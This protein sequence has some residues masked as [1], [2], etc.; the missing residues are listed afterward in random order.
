[1][2]YNFSPPCLR[3][4][5]REEEQARIVKQTILADVE[6]GKADASALDRVIGE[7]FPVL[8]FFQSVEGFYTG[9]LD[10][11]GRHLSRFDSLSTRWNAYLTEFVAVCVGVKA[12]TS[13]VKD[14]RGLPYVRHDLW[15]SFQKK[16]KVPPTFPFGSLLDHT[17]IVLQT[18]SQNPL[19]KIQKLCLTDLPPELLDE[20]FRHASLDKARLLS[21]TCRQLREIAHPYI[22]ITRSLSF[23]LSLDF[24]K[25]LRLVE[26]PAQY[27]AQLAR[28]SRESVLSASEFL[29]GR[30]ELINRMRRL[31][32]HDGWSLSLFEGTSI[33][34]FDLSDVE[35]DFYPPITRSFV[36]VLSAGHNL[37]SVTLHHI[38]LGL[39]IVRSISF[40]RNLHT[41]DL[42][43]CSLQEDVIDILL[44]DSSDELS[45]GVYNLR[46]FMDNDQAWYTLLLCP[47]LHTLSARSTHTLEMSAP[48]PDIWP[49]CKFYPTLERLWLE[50]V[51][52]LD[53]SFYAAWLCTGSASHLRL[54][55]FKL[56]TLP[57]VAEVDLDNVLTSL[58]RMPL[59]VL[60]LDGIHEG[61]FF[62]FIGIAALFPSLIA[63]TLIR[64]ASNR[65]LRTSLATWPH[66][67]WEYA[68]LLAPL[69]NLKHFGWNMDYIYSPP[70]PYGLL[71][72]EEGFPAEETDYL[73]WAEEIN[74]DSFGI[75][76]WTA[77]SF[78]AY[79]PSLQTYTITERPNVMTCRISRAP[80]GSIISEVPERL[81]N[82]R[83]SWNINH[84]NPTGFD[85]HW[86]DILPESAERNVDEDGGYY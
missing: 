72:F 47:N 3:L 77:L 7:I 74:A 36:D 11:T 17:I 54:T 85:G 70:T 55:H 29:L 68:R 21:S 61:G 46:L 65:Q 23:R 44:S 1:M 66:A 79:C 14:C 73:E 57:G 39:D 67:S 82:D 13:D 76:Y 35:D 81:W 15:D 12:F 25:N 37:T 75:D 2:F 6:A 69:Q 84:W 16:W 78:A 60:V 41:L 8:R 40:L 28:S 49:L 51:D 5:E 42:M 19:P 59:Q 30:P 43:L 50:H 38:T 32:I 62:L 26:D 52:I 24:W 18:I 80:D 63:L 56:H 34:G 83:D 10:L 86:Q 22:F 58:G 33:N 20:V 31:N 53:I 4:Y 64:R 27:M 71:R 9:S 45:W 48:P